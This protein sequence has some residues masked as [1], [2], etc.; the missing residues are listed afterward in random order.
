MRTLTIVFL[1]SALTG[2]NRWM[3]D[4]YL[5]TA[6]RAYNDGDCAA[7]RVELSKAE[8]AARSR[9]HLQPEISLLRGLCLEREKYYVDAQQTYLF[10]IRN[11][12]ASEYAFRAKA[13]LETLQKL[14]EDS[15][16]F[17]LKVTPE[18]M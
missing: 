16:N 10:V 13:R 8:R 18:P 3:L 2:C 15:G 12:P 1:L 17:A 4:N 14:G 5:N 7:V 6:N 11:Y 9:P